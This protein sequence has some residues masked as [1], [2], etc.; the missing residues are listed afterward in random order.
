MGRKRKTITA[1]RRYLFKVTWLVS[2]KATSHKI[3]PPY[4]LPN[5]VATPDYF[6]SNRVPRNLRWSEAKNELVREKKKE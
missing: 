3:A 1:E 5:L 4:F 6:V 2:I